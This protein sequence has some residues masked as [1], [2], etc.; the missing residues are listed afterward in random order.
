MRGKFLFKRTSRTEFITWSDHP[1]A[2]AILITYPSMYHIIL[3]V[4][5]VLELIIHLH[6]MYLFTWIRIQFVEST[7]ISMLLITVI[8]MQT[9]FS[10]EA[11]VW[12]ICQLTGF[13]V[14]K[15]NTSWWFTIFAC[16]HVSLPIIR[17]CHVMKPIQVHLNKLSLLYFSICKTSQGLY[18]E[19]N[20]S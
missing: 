2:H 12:R 9:Y 8:N 13:R 19:G 5:R 3:V 15:L 6:I 16:W 17:Y 11:G 10:F 14:S 7:N 18:Q 20:F 4:F 1:E